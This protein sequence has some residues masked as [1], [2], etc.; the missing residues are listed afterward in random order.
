MKIHLLCDAHGYP[1]GF[2]LSPE[3]QADSRNF[4]PLLDQVRL[5]GFKGRPCKRCRTGPL[6][7]C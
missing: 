1:L 5:P 2:T 6:N 7:A 3:Q 4:I